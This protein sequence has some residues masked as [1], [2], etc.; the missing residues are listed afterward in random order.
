MRMNPRLARFQSLS[1]LRVSVQIGM[2]LQRSR[3]APCLLL[4]LLRR[5]WN[6]LKHQLRPLGTKHHARAHRHFDNWAELEACWGA[7][8]DQ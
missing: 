5:P 3:V 1:S 7:G 4:Q 6:A 2:K 8:W